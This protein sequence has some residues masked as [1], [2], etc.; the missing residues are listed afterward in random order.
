[1]AETVS[2]TA[3]FTPGSRVAVKRSM[4]DG[5]EEAVID[6]VYKNGNFIIAGDKRQWKPFGNGSAYAVGSSSRWSRDRV[7]AWTPEIERKVVAHKWQKRAEWL[8]QKIIRLCGSLTP[9]QIIAIEAAIA[10]PTEQR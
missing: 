7:E 10:P 6:R 1:M 4:S 8:G 9:E 2:D 5:L 3:H